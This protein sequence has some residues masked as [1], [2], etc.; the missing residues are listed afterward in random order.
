[1]RNDNIHYESHVIRYV[2]SQYDIVNLN[3]GSVLLGD[4]EK[5]GWVVLKCPYEIANESEQQEYFYY[6]NNN[7]FSKEMKYWNKINGTNRERL[8]G[9]EN[10]NHGSRFC[11][12]EDLNAQ[13]PNI[14]QSNCY[15]INH[16]L[17][18]SYNFDIN[19]NKYKYYLPNMIRHNGFVIND[20]VPHLDYKRV[21]TKYKPKTVKLRSRNP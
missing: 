13:V 17:H 18:V 2:K 15:V 20:Q 5:V 11:D 10:H 16:H 6:I 14:F 21:L 12:V 19:E 7:T 3:M 1:M 8:Y 9:L 4:L